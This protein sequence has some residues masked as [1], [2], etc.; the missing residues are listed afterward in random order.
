MASSLRAG[1]SALDPQVAAAL[2]V[3]ADQPFVRPETLDQLADQHRRPSADCD[4]L[5]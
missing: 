3:L 2:I 1:L 4:P 5:L